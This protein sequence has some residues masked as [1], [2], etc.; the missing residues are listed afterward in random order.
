MN[1]YFDIIGGINM[2]IRILAILLVMCMAVSSVAFAA[3]SDVDT[4]ADYAEP[5]KLLSALGIFE[6]DERG[7]FNPENTVTRAE[8]AAIICRA[9]GLEDVAMASMGATQFTDVPASHWASGYVNMASQNGII[10]GYGDGRFGP[11]DTVTFAQ[12]VKMIV[13]ALG[14]EPMASQKGGWPTG[15]MVVANTYKITNGVSA[16]DGALR[17]SLAVMI[18]NA[19]STPMMDQ[20]SWGTDTEYG[21]MNGKNGRSY[22]SILT[23]MDIYIATAIVGEKDYDYVN[24]S[25]SAD[26]DDG[27]FLAGRS[28]R[29]LING[30]DIMDYRFKPVNVYLRKEAN[31]YHVVSVASAIDTNTLVII[32][33]DVE[34]YSGGKVTYYENS[35]VNSRTKSIRVIANPRIEYNRGTYSGTLSSLLLAEEDVRLEFVENTGDSIYDVIVASK[36]ISARVDTVDAKRDKITIG[37]TTVTLDMYDDEDTVILRDT[38]GNELTLSDFRE[39][40]VVAVAA[41][42]T[43]FKNYYDYIEI[44]RLKNS[45]VRGS[46][47]SIFTQNGKNYVVIDNEEYLDDTG[48]GL[49]VDD[50]GL[51]YIGLTGRIIDFE[52]S[53]AMKNYAYILEAAIGRT[54]VFS[55]NTWQLKLLTS[56]DGIVTYSLTDDASNY[57][58]STYASK[59]G[60]SSTD[61]YQG[62]N[63]LSASQKADPDR[64]ITYKVN[65]RGYIRSFESATVRGA[66]VKTFD[67][68]NDRYRDDIQSIGGASLEDNAVVFNLTSSSVDK[69]HVADISYLVDDG[70]Y[71]G[72]AFANENYEYC[73]MVITSGQ[74][75]F[76]Q[77]SGVAIVTKTALTNDSYGE[78]V[79]KVTFVQGEQEGTVI[80]ND[81]SENKNGSDNSYEM[82][83]TGDVFAYRMTSSG[84]VSEYVIL[85]SISNGILVPNESSYSAFDSDTEFVYGYISNSTPKSN[86]RGQ[87]IT[88]NSGTEDTYLIPSTA[89]KYTYDD[90]GRNT[91]IETGDYLSG[92]AYYYDAD[93]GEATFVFMRLTDGT[94]GDI[95]SFNRRIIVS[96]PIKVE[97]LI[98]AI[99]T[100]GYDAQSLEA[101]TKAEAAYNLLTHSEK[102]S[103][104]NYSALTA[105][106]SAYDALHNSEKASEVITLISQLG[107]AENTTAYSDKLTA[108]ESAYSLL[109]SAQKELVVNYSVLTAARSAYDSLSSIA[110]AQTTIDAINSIG[111]VT[112][113]NDSKTKIEDARRLYELLPEDKKQFVTNYAILQQA[114]SAYLSLENSDKANAVKQ[115]ITAIG[116]V[117]ATDA[118]LSKITAAEEAYA[119]LTTEQR[120][121]VDNYEVLTCAREAYNS[122]VN[123]M[124]AESVEAVIMSIGNIDTSDACKEKI[125]NAEKAYGSLSAQQK[126]LVDNYS[127]LE[128]ARELYEK[129]KTEEKNLSDFVRSAESLGEPTL[130]ESYKE[131]L[132]NAE[133]EYN[134]LTDSQKSQ[135]SAEYLVFVSKRAKYNE[136]LSA[137]AKVE[138]VETVISAIGRVDMTEASKLRIEAAEKEYQALPDDSKRLVT[139]YNVL[140]SA[141]LEYDTLSSDSTKAEQV[142]A[143]INA[144]GKVEN[145]DLC[146][147]TI[148]SAEKAYDALSAGQKKLVSNYA[149]LTAAR[150]A[151]DELSLDSRKA[152]EAEALIK[153]IG[154]VELT[155]KSK[156]KIES[157]QRVYKSLTE[158]QTSLVS[159]KATLDAAM[160]EYSALEKAEELKKPATNQSAQHI[161]AENK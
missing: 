41:D 111:Q 125:E 123:T 57:F 151:Y 44:I 25:V 135:V 114:E 47:E 23:D 20:T 87:V 27:E 92:D 75:A 60:I 119:N 146:R 98:K 37:G 85:G 66:N 86:A 3:Y 82:F 136:L 65:S 153:E 139:N 62:F 42:N 99:G 1:N 69:A 56:S 8:M 152:E 143:L 141:R 115:L 109:T 106:R 13:C 134:E 95:Y 120:E 157:A 2:K 128:D 14:Y 4:K 58:H 19:L 74:S 107:A 43:N 101:I 18:Y 67:S 150:K 105:A 154:K 52:G 142:K 29:A 158:K 129:L 73:V 102:A 6:G 112:L 33:D 81:D 97:M 78:P 113:T 94:V 16:S 155:A 84:Y 30:S 121:L 28:Y 40:D 131:A 24:L 91:V 103:V 7:N 126:L 10:N 133:R 130:T 161:P 79:K 45:A 12:A 137:L 59:L 145:T 35:S 100:V 110:E 76:T 83:A 93:T 159:V 5:L 17:R 108:A 148:E 116:E 90:S 156:N 118:C 22:R 80:F 70:R 149:V 124:G 31:K 63:T 38:E 122:I 36:Y 39:D 89:N 51:F 55:N 72:F 71:N 132:E 53:A 140:Q 9:K 64:L 160:A 127:S 88:V 104:R 50:T 96:A 21:I 77:L 68:V 34:D 61:T 138:E 147:K 144:I 32:S 11:E 117:E 54:D 15:Y 49:G 48:F 26:S 46:V